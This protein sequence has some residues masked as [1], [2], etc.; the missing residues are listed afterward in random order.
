MRPSILCSTKSCP[1]EDF[2]EGHNQYAKTETKM[3][4][5]K[6]KLKRNNTF[7][8]TQNRTWHTKKIDKP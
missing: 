5:K 2:V 4:L 6:K 3:N 7:K 8:N 1:G